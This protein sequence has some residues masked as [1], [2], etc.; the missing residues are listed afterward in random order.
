PADS[1]TFIV[2][3]TT[4]PETMLGDTAVAVH[5]DD[6]RYTHLVGQHVVLP[7][8]GRRIPIVA[9]EYSD[10]EKGSG[11]VK[12]TPA[13]DFNDFEVGK[14]HNLA[15]ISV[16]DKE[17]HLTLVGNDDYLHGLPE[18]AAELASELHGADRFAARKTIVAR[19]EDFGFLERVEPNTHMVPHGDR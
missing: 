11:A 19:L 14:R 17:A 1:K 4:R 6:E 10:P 2:V 5:P 13:H 16:L 9:D 7:L 15:Q 12:V 8:V 18:G 3:A